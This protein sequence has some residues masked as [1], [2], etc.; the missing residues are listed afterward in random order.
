MTRLVAHH[1]SDDDDLHHDGEPDS[2]VM[3]LQDNVVLHSVGVDIGSA[4]TQVAF[5]R[6]HLRRHAEDLTSR[7]VVV[8]RELV[9]DAGVRLTPYSEGGLI[10]APAIGGLLDEAYAGSGW[11][12][13]DIDTGAVI[14]TGEA[15][16]RTNSERIGQ[17]I[18]RRAGDLVC[19]T[20][21]HHM[22]ALLAA[23]GSGTVR[24]SHDDGTVLLNVDIGGGTTK[25]ALVDHG[26]V[27]GTCAILVGG[28]LIATGPGGVIVTLA[29]GGA[30]HA[31]TRG[32]CWK[33]GDRVDA[34]D[35]RAVAE[36]MVDAI[37]AAATGGD[38]APDLFLTEVVDL[39]GRVDGV[40]VSGG[41]SAYLHGREDRDFG[42]LGP[43]IAAAL[44]E[45]FA[46]GLMPGPLL[47]GEET[48]RATVV[49]AS[50]HTVQLS[51]ITGYISAPETS[52]PR[53]DLPVVRPVLELGAEVDESAVA[54]A[55]RRALE[56]RDLAHP[57]GDVVVALNWTGEPRHRRVSALAGGIASGLGDRATGGRS[58]YLMVDGDVAMTLGRILADEVGL[59]PP[60]V[61]LDGIHL[62]EFDH[63]DLGRIRPISGNVPITIKS[64][65]FAHQAN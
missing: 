23:Y 40:V 47:A 57:D 37:V 49:G 62:R 28:R 4:T 48:I 46:Q 55:V 53:R 58:V 32:L 59:R 12:A 10:D 11:T 61:V 5:S 17:V 19:V 6:L 35:F 41:V 31:A 36:T 9:H 65:V 33:V 43:G 38:S 26:R 34:R 21:G 30:R 7:Y 25:F 64:L 60:L 18:A 52:L 20:A 1:P 42:D 27:I 16:R 39:P 44:G 63:V 22:E 14:L 51:G 29:P 15:L 24:R 13:D 54:D 3:W 2:N 50:E 8:E 45:R 56:A